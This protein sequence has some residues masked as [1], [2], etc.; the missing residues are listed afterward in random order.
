MNLYNLSQLLLLWSSFLINY[1]S[2][3]I[4]FLMSFL[5]W[6]SRAKSSFQIPKNVFW[7][8]MSGFVTKTRKG[9]H[10]C[11]WT[12]PHP[13]QTLVKIWRLI[14][15]GSLPSVYRPTSTFY[16]SFP[17]FRS[18]TILQ[19]VRLYNCGQMTGG[20]G[21]KE[22]SHVFGFRNWFQAQKCRNVD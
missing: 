12:P 11:L 20:W 6:C 9:A 15:W 4:V 1:V 22:Y 13:T 18:Q 14:S 2:H 21:E 3:I 17:N 7:Q 10:T 8:E 5:P 16:S 19:D